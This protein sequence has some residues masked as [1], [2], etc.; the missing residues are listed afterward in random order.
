[1]QSRHVMPL[2]YVNKIKK[3][4]GESEFGRA[5]AEFKGLYSDRAVACDLQI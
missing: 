2:F 1:M 4:G 3:T 5:V